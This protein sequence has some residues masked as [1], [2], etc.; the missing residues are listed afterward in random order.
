MALS[1][2]PVSHE[3]VARMKAVLHNLERYS[4]LKEKAD[5]ITDWNDLVHD[6]N[7]L[8]SDNGADLSSQLKDSIQT[9]MNYT[10]PPQTDITSDIDTVKSNLEQAI[11]VYKDVGQPKQEHLHNPASKST[12]ILTGMTIGLIIASSVIFYLTQ[13]SVS[14]LMIINGNCLP[15]QFENA[16][17][18]FKLVKLPESPIS[19]GGYAKALIPAGTITLDNKVGDKFRIGYIFG[20]SVYVDLPD[21]VSEIKLN[22]FQSFQANQLSV[23]ALKDGRNTITISCS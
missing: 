15:L 18:P 21:N 19:K 1:D 13:Y 20:Q 11:D 2:K 14:T 16:N 6:L 4:E 12:I 22:N 8:V 5:G 9:I 10:E 23:E 17:Q 3:M 7:D